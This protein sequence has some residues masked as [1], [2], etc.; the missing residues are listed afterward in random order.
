MRRKGKLNSFISK[1]CYN[2]KRVEMKQICM[3]EDTLCLL[4]LSSY[5]KK[6]HGIGVK[7]MRTKDSLGLCE[8]G[9]SIVEVRRPH[10]CVHHGM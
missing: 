5:V 1:N 6:K 9:G 3:N 8:V 2:E 7:E 10:N 4:R